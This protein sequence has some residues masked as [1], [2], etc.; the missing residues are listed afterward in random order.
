M[1]PNSAFLENR[2][3]NWTLTSSKVRRS[4]RVGVA[5]GT[6]PQTVM[7]VL[8]ES[9]ARHGLVLK[10]PEPFATFDDFGDSALIFSLYF[11]VELGK[12]TNAMIVASDLRL[13]IEKRFTDA[14]IGVPYPQ[15]EMH[16]TTDKPLQIQ[17][18]PTPET[19]PAPEA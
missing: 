2:V 19:P 8:T 10:T 15:R 16:L 5:Y 7:A 12:G 4:L 18:A 6:S 1:I 13:M 17:M 14:G 3:T 9:A 11:W